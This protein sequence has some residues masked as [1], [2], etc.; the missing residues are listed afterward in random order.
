QELDLHHPDNVV[1]FDLRLSADGKRVYTL[2]RVFSGI[3]GSLITRLALWDAGA[4]KPLARHAVPTASQYVAWLAGGRAAVVLVNDGLTMF[5]VSS[6]TVR[7]RFAGKAVDR[8]LVV[9]PD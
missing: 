2:H 3:A 9:S 6:G 1:F 4:G 7:L 8:P 5:D